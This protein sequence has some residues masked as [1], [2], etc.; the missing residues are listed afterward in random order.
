M[1]WPKKKGRDDLAN[2]RLDPGRPELLLD[3]R[4]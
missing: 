3:S 4:P 1:V 2:F